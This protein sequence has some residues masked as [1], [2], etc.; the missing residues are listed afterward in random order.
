MNVE[1]GNDIKVIAERIHQQNGI[2][3]CVNAELIKIGKNSKKI[4][5]ST[6]MVVIIRLIT[7][8]KTF[9]DD[10][11]VYAFNMAMRQNED[12]LSSKLWLT[13]RTT[14][15]KIVKNGT[16]R[17]W[18]WLKLCLLPSTIWYQ[19]ISK[20][21]GDSKEPHY[22]YYE[23]LKLVNVEAMNQVNNLEEGINKMVAKQRNDWNVLIKYDLSSSEY[24]AARQDV[25]VNGI[26]SRYTFEQLS[27]NSDTNFNSPQFYDYNQYLSQ[28]VL[29]AQIGTSTFC[30]V[31][32]F[33][34]QLVAYLVD[35][36]FQH[37][38]QKI[39]EIDSVSSKGKIASLDEKSVIS[40][41]Y[42]RGP[43]KLMERARSK[44]Q[45]D[46]FGEPY[47][48]SAC[49]LD[50]NRCALIF[51][52]ISSLLQ[53]LRLFVKKVKYY[54]S[55]NIIAIARVKNGFIE[56]VKD[57]QYSDIKLNV[58][59]KGKHNS[60]IGEVQ[61][62]LRTMKDFKEVAHNLYMIQRKE[63]P[64][65][66]SVSQ[67]LPIL[68]DQKKGIGG[69]A[70][71]GSW[72]EMCSLMVL[73]NK[74]IK[75]LMFVD[76]A[77]GT[78][79]FHYI[80]KFGHL[81]LLKFFDSMM[82]R[83]EFI[84]HVLL[85]NINAQRPIDMAVRYM[86]SSSLIKFLFD[87]Q[88]FQNRYKNN[89]KM[90]FVL[91]LSVFGGNPDPQITKYILSALKIDKAKMSQMLKYQYPKAEFEDSGRRYHCNILTVTLC[92]G[93]F[94]NLKNLIDFVGEQ[95]FIDSVF[96]VDNSGVD[97][98]GEAVQNKAMKYVK[99]IL[100]FEEI[101]S[102]YMSDNE[103]LFRL[104]SSLNAQIGNKEIVKYVCDSLGLTAEKIEKLKAFRDINIEKIL[105][106]TNTK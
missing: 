84:D 60:I 10:Q 73:Q 53:G 1:A 105:S 62:L 38:V 83:K 71:N 3:E 7:N 72:R 61:F 25:I 101:Q 46:Y 37:S 77:S 41:E 18:M 95:A 50:F 48:A 69:I 78:N 103:L 28:L 35:G 58:V 89:D 64:M 44:A 90:I 13:I 75:D 54:Q 36:K 68:L 56:Y 4:Y 20:E 66:S 40:V 85:K 93:T 96:S 43:I 22:L 42:M 65:R 74:S 70:C 5:E 98:M 106:F 76:E 104:C 94:A 33:L 47:P 6:L 100:S 34:H 59:I 21:K 11:L 86:A 87:M 88:D 19:D 2:N 52:D 45:N 26:A 27:A 55:G 67:I 91:L 23:L 82:D 63:E 17:D 99:Y 49:V 24:D 39:F 51:E 31:S 79:I 57:A 9:A 8:R 81:K 80:C 30:F 32:F 102:K 12:I 16:K 29:L 15:S 97:L 92:R 14:C